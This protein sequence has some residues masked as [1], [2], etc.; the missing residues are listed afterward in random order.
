MQYD[1]VLRAT[2]TSRFIL[3][4]CLM[5]C[6][7]TLASS[8][9]ANGQELRKTLNDYKTGRPFQYQPNDPF[10]RSKAFQIQT[11]HYGL[12]R[13]CDTEECKRNSPHICWKV[14]HEKDLP[15]TMTALQRVK[16]ELNQVRQ[17]VLDGAG[18]CAG[19]CNCGQCQAS[20]AAQSGGCSCGQ[21]SGAAPANMM[22]MEAMPTNA[23][24]QGDYYIGNSNGSRMNEIGR[25]QMERL[26][27]AL[28]ATQ[29]D[30]QRS[31][32]DRLRQAPISNQRASAART[33]VAK[34]APRYSPKPVANRVAE[35]NSSTS[36]LDR[37]RKV[38]R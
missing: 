15:T 25:A 28:P 10:V 33:T 4:A 2:S 1:Y 38:Q 36:L 19:D 26:A 16:H 18:S 27:K 37:L 29:Q 12:F 7:F 14:H 5:A 13:D 24:P 31:M 20:N 22:P 30:R 34:Q 11:K 3:T 21:C 8:N 6:L 17:R 35:R 9:S 23:A 32:T